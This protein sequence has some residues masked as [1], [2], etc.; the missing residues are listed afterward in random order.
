MGP[1]PARV[2]TTSAYPSWHL[3][4]YTLPSLETLLRAASQ[5]TYSRECGLHST[6]KTTE[7]SRTEVA[8]Y[9]NATPEAQT[10]LFHSLSPSAQNNSHRWAW[11]PMATWGKG[12]PA[13]TIK[14]L[15]GT[16]KPTRGLTAQP[17]SLS[18][19]SFPPLP[20]GG[21][22]SSPFSEPHVLPRPLPPS[23]THSSTC[24]HA[25]AHSLILDTHPDT[26]SGPDNVLRVGIRVG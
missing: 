14:D 11:H 23:L 12:G 16:S 3:T 6:Q 15:P 2:I 18:L 19:L 1:L 20:G 22:V 8:A 10:P 7:C 9:P 26:C 4:V 17:R 25:C 24:P 5:G 13:P 21:G